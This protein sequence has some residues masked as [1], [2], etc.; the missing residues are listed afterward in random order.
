MEIP[1]TNNDQKSGNMDQKL[2]KPVFPFQYMQITPP[3]HWALV[4]ALCSNPEHG[5]YAQPAVI[6]RPTDQQT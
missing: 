3:L 1:Y 4:L 6:N 2:P 5:L